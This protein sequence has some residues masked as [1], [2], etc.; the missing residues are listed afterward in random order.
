VTL[1]IDVSEVGDR[2]EEA[3]ASAAAG[4]EVVLERGGRAVAELRP[5]SGPKKG[6]RAFYESRRGE[7]FTQV[8]RDA[9]ED[10]A[11]D[12]ERAREMLNRPVEPPRLPEGTVLGDGEGSR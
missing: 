4:E 5:A 3:L 9:W 7:T 1:R 12:V 11:K 6:L 10:F 8:D 2:I